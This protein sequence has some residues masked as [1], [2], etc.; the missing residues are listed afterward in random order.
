VRHR[1]RR[2]KWNSRVFV[3]TLIPLAAAAWL[4]TSCIASDQL[5]VITVLEDGSADWLRFQSNIR[6]TEK[7]EKGA[8]ELRR[9]I[10]DFDARKDPDFDRIRAAGGEILDSRW[11]RRQEPCATIASARLPGPRALESFLTMKDEEG[12]AVVQARFT[13]DGTRRRLSM[14]V[15][16]P[17]EGL[18]EQRKEPDDDERRRE[19]ADGISGTRIAVQPGRIL[20][21]RGFSVATDGRSALLDTR[22]VET[23]MRAGKGKAE[24]FIEWDLAAN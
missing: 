21:S 9:F 22:E 16:V 13:R 7:G 12:K 4:V 3:K 15:D 2:S 14:S 11:I 8:E 10:E 20:T 6:S 1:F 23:L 18:P 19:Q 17:P 24:I 5:T